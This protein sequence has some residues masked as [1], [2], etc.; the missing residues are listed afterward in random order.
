MRIEGRLEWYKVRSGE[1]LMA[2]EMEVTML[3]KCSPPAESGI[4]KETDPPLELP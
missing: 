3:K 2:L 1:A 4:G